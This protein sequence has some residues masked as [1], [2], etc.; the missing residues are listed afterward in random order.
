MFF[1]LCSDIPADLLLPVRGEPEQPAA[2][3]GHVPLVTRHADQ[4]RKSD[5]KGTVSRD[6]FG[7]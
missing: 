2:A 1:F 3:E 5:I 7:F 6:E 4:V